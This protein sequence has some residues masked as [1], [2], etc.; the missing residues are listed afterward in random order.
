M[1]RKSYMKKWRGLTDSE[2]DDELAQIALERQI[3][4]ESFA[5]AGDTAYNELNESANE[6]INIETNSEVTE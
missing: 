1:S 2:V 4:E 5:G 3:I 6:L